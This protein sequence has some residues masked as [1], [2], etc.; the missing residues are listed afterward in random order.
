LTEARRHE[1][2]RHQCDLLAAPFDG[3]PSQQLLT[4]VVI[5]HRASFWT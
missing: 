4:R 3:D 5:G 1:N 2:A